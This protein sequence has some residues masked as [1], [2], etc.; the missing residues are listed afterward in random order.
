MP[1]VKDT[2]VRRVGRSK[3]SATVIGPASGL[4]A[5]RVLLHRGR[6]REHLGLLGR[7]EVVVGEEVAG[8]AGTSLASRIAGHA[9]MNACASAS[10]RTS[11]GHEPD[12]G[13]AGG[14]EDEALRHRR[15]DDAPV[16][17][18]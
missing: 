13:R 11:G 6:E 14:V 18:C 10:V 3:T 2:W 1:A 5:V 17:R 12:R 9:S 15:G 4:V 8:H 16:R 7:G